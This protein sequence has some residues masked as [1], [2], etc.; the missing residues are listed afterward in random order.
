MK[1]RLKSVRLVV[2]N[3][4]LVGLPGAGKTLLA[5][6]MPGIRLASQSPKGRFDIGNRKVVKRSSTLS[7]LESLQELLNHC[8]AVDEDFLNAL[9]NGIEHPK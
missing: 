8:G 7:G 1:H 2:Y 9:E 4:I 5:R 3:M 6:A